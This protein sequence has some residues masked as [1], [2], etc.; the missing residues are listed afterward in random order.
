MKTY[1]ACY[2]R[3]STAEQKTDSQRKVLTDYIRNHRI[4]NVKW[5]QDKRS[6]RTIKRPQLQRLIED[7]RAGR[8]SSILLYRL[9]RLARNT[10]ATLELFD[11][12][13][14]LKVKVV[15]VSQGLVFDNSA[16]GKLMLTLWAALAEH[17]SML[18]SERIKAGLA[19]CKN[20]GGA[21]P[22]KR[23]RLKISRMKDKGLSLAEI[24]TAT[25]TTRQSV[26]A[27]LRRI[28]A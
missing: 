24:A 25:G 19:A 26:H 6:G 2:L 27:M 28:S 8:C 13:I 10:R 12:L 18:L 14:A 15:C 16:T 22:D 1:T 4:K 17:E 11:E 21:A 20:R 3:V 5:L 23:K 9:D 7:C